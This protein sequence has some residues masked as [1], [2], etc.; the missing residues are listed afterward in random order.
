MIFFSN[1]TLA[2]KLTIQVHSLNVFRGDKISVGLLP[3]QKMEKRKMCVFLSS[4]SRRYIIILRSSKLLLPSQRYLLLVYKPY[5]IS[6]VVWAELFQVTF[7][8]YRFLKVPS[9]HT[10]G[11]RVTSQPASRPNPRRARQIG[12]LVYLTI[13]KKKEKKGKHT[14]ANTTRVRTQEQQEQQEQH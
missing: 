11:K 4:A 7:P 13:K 14:R 6:L 12:P 5:Y 1:F 2:K 3:F 10:Q 9:L 8:S